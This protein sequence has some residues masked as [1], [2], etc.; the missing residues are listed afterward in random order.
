MIETPV[1]I[2]TYQYGFYNPC[3]NVSMLCPWNEYT[4]LFILFRTLV[5]MDTSLKLASGADMPLLGLGTWQVGK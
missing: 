2:L 1:A 5:A 4:I 3:I